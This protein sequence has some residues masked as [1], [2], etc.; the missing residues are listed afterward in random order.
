VQLTFK[1][2]FKYTISGFVIYSQLD[3]STIR[4]IANTREK[5]AENRQWMD[6]PCFLSC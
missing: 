2:K 5:L 6:T 3:D 1:L 4:A